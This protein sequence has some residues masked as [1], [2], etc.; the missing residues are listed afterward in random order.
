MKVICFISICLLFGY[1]WIVFHPNDLASV[2]NTITPVDSVMSLS[3][4]HEGLFANDRGEPN[5][6]VQYSGGEKISC[7][8]AFDIRIGEG[9]VIFSDYNDR[10]FLLS[11]TFVIASSNARIGSATQE[12]AGELLGIVPEDICHGVVMNNSCNYGKN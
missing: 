11:G 7:W 1:L 2:K 3:L 10:K 12:K 4:K 9:Y 6:I 5:I 8:R